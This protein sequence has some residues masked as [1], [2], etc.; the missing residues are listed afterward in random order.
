MIY[1]VSDGTIDG[2]TLT[3][4]C[5]CAKLS[6]NNLAIGC[7]DGTIYSC[8]MSNIG[9]EPQQLTSGGV[10]IN[11][12]DVC[13]NLQNLILAGDSTNIYLYKSTSGN[14]FTLVQ[15]S[16]VSY[17]TT[18]IAISPDNQYAVTAN[19]NNDLNIYHLAT[20]LQNFYTIHYT[21]SINFITW[22]LAGNITSVLTTLQLQDTTKNFILIGFTDTIKAINFCF[23]SDVRTSSY[24]MFNDLATV[25][26]PKTINDCIFRT[27]TTDE[28]TGFFGNQYASSQFLFI[29]YQNKP[30]VGVL[31]TDRKLIET[32]LQVALEYHQVPDDLTTPKTI[33]VKNVV[34]K[35]D[36][37]FLPQYRDVS[38]SAPLD[39]SRQN[40]LQSEFFFCYHL[41]H[42][43]RILS[44]A[45]SDVCKPFITKFTTG[46]TM[47]C[48]VYDKKIAIVFPNNAFNFEWRIILNEH[49]NNILGLS[50]VPHE[51]IPNA[52]VLVVK[53]ETLNYYTD[54]SR[55]FLP[56]YYRPTQMF[57]FRNICFTSQN[58]PIKPM[59]K[60]NN[61]KK[62]NDGQANVITDLLI[63]PQFEDEFYD[64]LEYTPI[65][66]DRKLNI[67]TS[68]PIKDISIVPILETTDGYCVPLKL[69]T[70]S[71][72]SI[73]IK[74][75]KTA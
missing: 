37:W 33:Y 56:E 49:L 27:T 43:A 20:T 55:W 26:T 69:A 24:I 50:T 60:F 32:N 61:V 53:T 2:F 59:M 63:Y 34:Y 39:L 48:V 68:K 8:D 25:L 45:L 10:Q 57:P 72:A 17:S 28:I 7:V 75:D 41:D 66:Y 65:S 46:Q 13:S 38:P 58:L 6:G 70:L 19:S 1:N 21:Q 29:P 22:K 36:S 11:S 9:S 15:Q 71:S 4:N 23:S 51:T 44:D 30:W 52:H 18:K 73:M 47:S 67:D 16:V 42:F 5:S 31:D 3:G 64:I 35:N 74:F 54:N 12:I 40:V 14:P 62:E